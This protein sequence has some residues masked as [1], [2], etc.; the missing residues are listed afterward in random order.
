MATSGTATWNPSFRDAFQEAYERC[1]L[2]MRTGYEYATAVRSFNLLAVEWANRQL[3]MWEF[4]QTSLTLTAGTTSYS[5]PAPTIDVLEGTIRLNAGNTATQ[6]DLVI[7]RTSMTD[8]VAIPNKL[9]QGQPT[10]YT[11]QRGVDAPTVYFY[12]TPDGSQTY[13]F[14]YLRLVR[15][16][17]AGS[18]PTYNAAVPFRLYDAFIA[19]IA[20]RLAGKRR[21]AMALLPRLKQEYEDALALAESEDRDRSSIMLTPWCQ[22]NW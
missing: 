2:E 6:S 3:M 22:Q 10:Q 18:N 13:T 20:Y 11:I 7:S 14:F 1:G 16:E 5:L 4:A 15:T 19:G 17:D 21:E 8:Y 9:T 12:P